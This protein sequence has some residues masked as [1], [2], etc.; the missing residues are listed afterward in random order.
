MSKKAEALVSTRTTEKQTA[1]AAV[2]AAQT[3]LANAKSTVTAAQNELNAANEM[4]D[5]SDKALESAR[6][7][8]D[9]AQSAFDAICGDCALMVL[10]E[11]VDAANAALD[12][13][14]TA[15]QQAADKLSAAETALA[16]ANAAAADAEKTAETAKAAADK[17][18]HAYSE[19][20]IAADRARADLSL[21]KQDYAKAA[22]GQTNPDM[23]KSPAHVK[24]ANGQA[25]PN[26]AGA[27]I[28]AYAKAEAE[29]CRKKAELNSLEQEY[30][31]IIAAEKAL[32]DAKQKA[33]DAETALAEANS[34]VDK[35]KET[36][37]AK[38]LA[39]TVTENR[40]MRASNLSL[41]RAME[42][43]ISDPEFAYL[44]TYV[45]AVKAAQAEALA[46][47]NE[48]DQARATLETRK[49]A[50]DEAAKRYAAA[51]A[52]LTV[53]RDKK[54]AESSSAEVAQAVVTPLAAPETSSETDRTETAQ[55]GSR[56]TIAE[57]VATGDSG[58]APFYLFDTVSAAGL[59]A[60]LVK[61]KKDR[62]AVAVKAEKKQ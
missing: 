30:S 32:A 6:I 50:R 45:E 39:K 44:N 18:A 47:A 62:Q 57:S 52:D 41:D 11:Y 37:R 33:S 25:N 26:A 19:A 2:T 24:A 46:A 29:A 21:L 22:N 42:T 55:S 8:R 38:K 12:A 9:N 34:A 20:K 56:T 36:L 60:A 59:L 14:K 27:A 48:L 10:Q 7:T 15:R 23:A 1:D 3:K 43:P 58:A 53:L 35:T 49:L 31:G 16:G 13:A 61:K 54:N 4:L 51:L 28:T 40:L 17:A 5:A